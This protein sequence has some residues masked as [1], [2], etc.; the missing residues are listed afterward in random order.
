MSV[1]KTWVSPAD[2]AGCETFEHNQPDAQRRSISA[3]HADGWDTS[4]DGM[5]DWVVLLAFLC[6]MVVPFAFVA[7]V[8][9]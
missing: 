9:A 7:W 5:S 1:G 2:F 3:S 4:A 6:A 8:M